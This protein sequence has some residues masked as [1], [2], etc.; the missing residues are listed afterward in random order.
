MLQPRFP[1]LIVEGP[2]IASYFR[3]HDTVELYLQTSAPHHVIH[4]TKLI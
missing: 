4:R 1:P 2:F 3:R